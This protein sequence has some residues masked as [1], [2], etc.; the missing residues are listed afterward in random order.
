MHRGSLASTGVVWREEGREMALQ[1][2]C[3]DA[4]IAVVGG[5]GRGDSA[6]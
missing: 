5:V 6:P 2:W 4:L 1:R 3:E